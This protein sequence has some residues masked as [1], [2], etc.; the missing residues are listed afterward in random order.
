ML[1]KLKFN[2]DQLYTVVGALFFLVIVF[3]FLGSF[4]SSSQVKENARLAVNQCGE[5]N[6]KSVSTSSFS[7]KE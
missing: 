4:T 3:H 6:V 2:R 7:C 1:E 5:G